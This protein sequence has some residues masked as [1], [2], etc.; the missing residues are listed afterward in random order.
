MYWTAIVIYRNDISL[1]TISM[2]QM[3]LAR[4]IARCSVGSLFRRSQVSRHVSTGPVREQVASAG[5]PEARNL[6]HDLWAA[7]TTSRLAQSNEEYDWLC[8]ISD[9]L[10]TSRPLLICRAVESIWTSWSWASEPVRP[11][12]LEEEEENH[13][14]GDDYDVERWRWW[15]LWRICSCWWW[16]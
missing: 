1:F 6:I 12:S 11:G 16:W 8:L 7:I 9:S 14:V 4:R 2:L 5:Y 13:E 10:K 15:W 3:A